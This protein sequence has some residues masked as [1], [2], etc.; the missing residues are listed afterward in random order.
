KE[1]ADKGMNRRQ[2]IQR[3]TAMGISAYALTFAFLQKSQQ[4]VAQGDDNPLGVDPSAPLDVVIFKG[5]YGDDYAINVNENIYGALYPDAEISYVGT[6][7]LMDEYQAQI[8]DGNPPDIM[9]NSGAN[10]FDNVTLVQDGLLADLT[11]LMEAPA[12][13]QDGVTFADSLME[14]T[15][16]NG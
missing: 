6:Q 4:A 1:V 9:D 16:V 14:G 3:A 13:G 8:V 2:M 10:M 7:R 11:D 5:G 12:Y 15:Q